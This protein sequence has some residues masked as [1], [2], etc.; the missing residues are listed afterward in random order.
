MLLESLY[1]ELQTL[2][3]ELIAQE[4][5]IPAER[6]ERLQKLRAYADAHEPARL[7]FICT[8][9]SRRSHLGMIWAALAAHVAERSSLEAYSGGT[10]ATAM[11]PRTVAALRRAGFRVED[12]GGDNPR[13]LVRFS[14][15]APALV[16]FSKVFD[17]PENPTGEFAAVMT[18]D[19]A[20][21]N[22]PF[23]P[24]A[25]LRL[26]LTYDDPKAADDTPGEAAR[27][28]ER[29]RQIGREILWA[30]G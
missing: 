6:R 4:D 15:N 19:H 2:A 27:Y 20:D 26:P 30:L 24:G 7:N 13:Y 14:D 3:K 29:L 28:D 12:P 8:H 16:C 10:E 17:H 18:C 1:P 25:K 9:N 11:N 22:C 21:Q 5:R 23:I